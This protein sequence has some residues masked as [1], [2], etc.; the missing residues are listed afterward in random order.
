VSV[1]HF[2]P[3][4]RL[5]LPNSLRAKLHF[6]FSEGCVSDACDWS[7]LLSLWLGSHGDYSPTAPAAP[8]LILFVLCGYLVRSEPV[9]MYQYRFCSIA[10]N[11]SFENVANFTSLVTTRA[12]LNCIHTKLR[13]QALREIT[14][15]CRNIHKEEV[16]FF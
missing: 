9:Q 6:F 7:R 12:K 2:S 1:C 14:E 8:S 13:E 3:F 16:H 10:A 4:L 11:A 15:R 5:F